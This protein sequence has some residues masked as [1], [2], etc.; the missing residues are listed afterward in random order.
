MRGSCRTTGTGSLCAVHCIRWWA[1]AEVILALFL[2]FRAA[3]FLA[4]AVP[5]RVSYAIARCGGSLAFYAWSGGRQ[6]CVENMLHVMHGDRATATRNA[7][8]SFGNY[9]VYLVDFFR[10]FGTDRAEVDRRVIVD[11][12]LW[13][14][15]REERRGNGIVFMTMHFGNWDLGAAILA[16][17]GFAISAIADVFANE[18]VNRL[19]IGSRE[20]LGMKI[21]PANRMG[22]G[23]LRALKADDVV[24]L[25]VDV[26][27]PETGVR[28]L[29]RHDRRAGRPGADCVA[30][31]LLGR[32]R[33]ASQAVAV[34]RRRGAQHRPGGV[35][36]DRRDGH[37]RPG[38][39]PGCLLAPG[40]AGPTS[41][42]AVVHLPQPLGRRC[43]ASIC[44][45]GGARVTRGC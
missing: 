28:V 29:R 9:F 32:S 13:D 33:D 38:T 12:G 36:A 42:G 35:H 30:R 26:P 5:L 34:E 3:I 24:A 7:R 15:L 44:R 31:G 21:I 39:D 25:L 8:R 16:Q 43:P 11:D 10:F 18:R 19:V 40:G 27:E 17:S 37:G 4:R 45:A 6:R 41:P 1:W 14:R 22:P 2:A 20:H 23:I